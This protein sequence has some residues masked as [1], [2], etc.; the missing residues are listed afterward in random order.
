MIRV[1]KRIIIE[2]ELS[3]EDANKLYMDLLTASKNGKSLVT[4]DF[5]ELLGKAIQ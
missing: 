2:M 1:S 4:N 3:A 5:L